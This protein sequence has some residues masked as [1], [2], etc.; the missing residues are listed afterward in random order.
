MD[1]HIRARRRVRR[2]G[3][4]ALLAAAGGA[5]AAAAAVPAQAAPAITVS[6]THDVLVGQRVTMRGNTGA[7]GA[8]VSIQARHGRGWAA[9]AHA[10]SAADGS[11]R[12][13]WRPARLGRYSV[14]AVVVGPQAFVSASSSTT[15]AVTVYRAVDASYYGP[16]LY[17]SQLACGGT[18]EPGQLGV[19]NKTLP[20]GSRV[21]LRYH[22]RSVTVPVIDRGPYV[23]GRE[24]D[25]TEAT[26]SR[27]EFPS[28]GSLWS[29]R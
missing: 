25:L 15:A 20:C 6:T 11:F 12:A 16:G 9:V 2:R 7:P 22:G 28:T 27:L 3:R 21:T 23:A 8:R 5:A 4:A 13:S 19:A 17:G 14:R 26:K 10:T 18:L 24:Y 29:S 1:T